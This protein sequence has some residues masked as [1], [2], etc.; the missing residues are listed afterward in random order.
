M[1]TQS[2]IHQ[3]Q[4][5]GLRRQFAHRDHGDD[6]FPIKLKTV[7][8]NASSLRV[9]VA[10]FLACVRRASLGVHVQAPLFGVSHQ[11]GRQPRQVEGGII[12]PR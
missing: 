2:E 1:S 6:S 12:A 11:H 9:L 3:P 8:V 4:H 10:S 5:G 7:T